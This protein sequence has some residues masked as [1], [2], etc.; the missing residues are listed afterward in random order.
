[1]GQVSTALGYT[2]HLVSL[3]SKCA[4][5]QAGGCGRD[6]RT[7]LRYLGV[8]LRYAPRH[9]ASRSSMRDDVVYGRPDEFPLFWRG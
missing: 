3:L 7:V 2:C 6:A 5:R 9:F 8:P 4:R 1:M